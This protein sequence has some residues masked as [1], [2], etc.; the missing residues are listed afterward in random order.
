V[1]VA[2]TFGLLFWMAYARTSSVSRGETKIR[3]IAL[4]QSV[5]PARA[6]QI[7]NNYDSQFALP[8]LFYV[9]VILAWITKHADLIFV[10]M[11]WLFVLLRLLHAYIHTT[12]N[13]VPTRFRAFAAG[14]FVLLIMWIIFAVRILLALP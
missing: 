9:L 6:Q 3:D 7:S 4:G 1:Q 8:L 5:W 13:H 12:S 14:M 2:L 11:A 10:V